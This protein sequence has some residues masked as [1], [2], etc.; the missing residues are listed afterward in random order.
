MI[1]KMNLPGYKSSKEKYQNG[2]DEHIQVF[3][4]DIHAKQIPSIK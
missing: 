4:F 2:N 1:E 3:N